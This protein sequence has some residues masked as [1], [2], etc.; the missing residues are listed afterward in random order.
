[1]LLLAACILLPLQQQAVRPPQRLDL[2][3]VGSATS[4]SGDTDDGLAA[5]AWVDSSLGAPRVLLAVS[6]DTG[7]TWSSPAPV[8]ADFSGAAK[9]LLDDSVSVV[10]G[11]IRVLWLDDR[12]GAGYDDLYFRASRDGGLS[13]DPEIRL[14]S[15]SAP[16]SASVSFFRSRADASGQLISVAAI[17]GSLPGGDEVRTL[18]S[19]DGGVNFGASTLQHAGGTVARLDLARHGA[20]LHLVWMDDSVTPSFNS[21]S[22]QRSLDDGQSWL[23]S[24]PMI[25]DIVNTHP[26]ELSIAA[27]GARVIVVFQDLY[28]IHAVGYNLSLD[29]GTTWL[30]AAKR[31]GGSRSPTVTPAEPRVLLTPSDILVCWSDD[32]TTSGFLTPW[33]AATRNGGA[34]WHEFKLDAGYGVSPHIQ[35]GETDGSFAVQWQT[36]A[37]VKASGSRAADPDPLPAFKVASA[38]AGGSAIA[39]ARLRHDAAYAHHLSYWLDQSGSGG[40]QV[41]VGGFRLPSVQM[42]GSGQAGTPLSFQA[43]QF[44]AADAG[45]SVQVLLSNAQGMAMLPFGDGRSTGL[46]AGAWLSQSARVGALRA[47]L[48]AGGGALTS[49][50]LIPA[51]LPAG[52]RVWYCGVVFDAAAHTFGDLTDIRDFVVQ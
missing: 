24:A 48:G 35:G 9:R 16:G 14:D 21:A 20:E 10:A 36:P 3:A 22:Y 49:S 32:R 33:L 42:Q 40:S 39:G 13:W 37:K 46:A 4:L 29:G 52:A 18:R 31:L 7:W 38:A 8:D 12:H 47:T 26:S 1:M 28:A 34:S 44:R 43:F 45:R 17:V 15:G 41:W 5:V 51:G 6:R 25:S 50:V 23:A 27:D 11:E 2:P 30:P 19:T